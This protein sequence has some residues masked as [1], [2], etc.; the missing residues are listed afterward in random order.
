MVSSI[1]YSLGVGSGVDTASLIRDLAAAARGPR[2][3]AL[4]K[5]ENLNRAQI[6]ALAS[7]TGALDTFAKA[8]GELFDGPGLYG[9]LSSSDE[10]RLG[11]SLTSGTRPSG[12]PVDVAIDAL[13]TAQVSRSATSPDRTSAMGT[14][15][16]TLTTA[17][18]AHSIDLTSGDTSLDGIAAAINAADT[19][20]A[21]R[22]AVDKSGARLVLSGTTGADNEFSLSANLG[23]SLTLT[24]WANGI[25]KVQSAGD[26]AI[27]VDGI[28]LSYASNTVEGAIA[29]TRLTLRG[30]TAP[31]TTIRVGAEPPEATVSELLADYV[32]AYNSLRTALN[33]AVASGGEGGSGG[34]L[35]GDPGVREMMRSLSGLSLTALATSGPVQTLSDLGIK[36]ARDGTLSFDKARFDAAWTAD[37]EA[38]RAA[39]DP[40]GT[41]G[42]AD[43]LS[44]A[45]AAVRDRLNGEGGALTI[46][47][48]RFDA[49]TKALAASREKLEEND[50]RLKERLTESFARMDSKMI[51]LR[52]AQSQIQQ[53][54]D[55]WNATKG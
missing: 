18:G 8:L 25:T 12:S 51:L 36:T 9:S 15:T 40:E 39:L 35:A 33:G 1:A 45:L 38:V 34:P 23:S 27:R 41:S 26:A 50:A 37:P 11:A 24:N 30:V 29:G 6:S 19:G 20:V 32:T 54:I 17:S 55:A 43:G 52:S 10:T 44:G 31:G 28:A 5:A 42:G 46:S 21:A 4:A 14:G 7:A 48:A 16:L 49:R 2:E 3:T 13:A 47:K 53:Q 22:V